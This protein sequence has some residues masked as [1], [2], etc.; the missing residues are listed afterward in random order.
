NRFGKSL[1]DLGLKLFG[2]ESLKANLRFAAAGTDIDRH[3]LVA[4][5]VTKQNTPLAVMGEGQIAKPAGFNVAARR[6]MDMRRETAPIEEQDNLA[7]VRQRVTHRPFQ[8]GAKGA[9]P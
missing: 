4:A 2:A 1:L 3:L 9:E 8:R 7:L 6:T 5:V